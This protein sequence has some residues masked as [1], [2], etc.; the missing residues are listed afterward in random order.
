MDTR[1]LRILELAE[2]AELLALHAFRV[3]GITLDLLLTTGQTSDGET[4][5]RLARLGDAP[6]CR[7][8]LAI[9]ES[10]AMRA[11]V[12]EVTRAFTGHLSLTEKSR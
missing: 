4:L 9:D 12:I 8:G 7:D 6:V 2:S 10:L 3:V 1:H 11:I 5:A